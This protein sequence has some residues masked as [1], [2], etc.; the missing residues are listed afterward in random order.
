MLKNVDLIPLFIIGGSVV[1]IALIALTMR[2]IIRR[3]KAMIRGQMDES[4]EVAA[5]EARWRNA[6]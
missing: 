3:E 5:Y 4:H 1:L 2:A 6:A